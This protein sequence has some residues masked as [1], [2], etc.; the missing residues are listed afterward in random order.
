RP[1]LAVRA[2][3]GL[4]LAHGSGHGWKTGGSAGSAGRRDLDGAYDHAHGA[5]APAS[6]CHGAQHSQTLLA[7]VRVP[8]GGVS[9]GAELHELHAERLVGPWRGVRHPAVRPAAPADGGTEP[10][11]RY[12]GLPLAA[13]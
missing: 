12:A 6:L 5:V 4:H 2:R 7:G 11:I 8:A 10:D 9:V 1:A 13:C 3:T